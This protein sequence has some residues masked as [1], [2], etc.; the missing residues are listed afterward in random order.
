MHVHMKDRLTCVPAGVDP[1]VKPA[2][3]PIQIL[4]PSLHSRQ[5]TVHTHDLILVEIEV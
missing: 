4:D 1:D 2:D 3:G 5:H